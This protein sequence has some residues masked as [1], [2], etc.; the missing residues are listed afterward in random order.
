MAPLSP[1]MFLPYQAPL[2]FRFPENNKLLPKDDEPLP[3]V[4]FAIVPETPPPATMVE[5]IEKVAVE[6]PPSK[7]LSIRALADQ[8]K[9]PEALALCEEALAS[10]KLDTGLHYL[11]A[12]ILQELDRME[13]AGASLKRTLYLDPD[14]ML[15]H[16]ALGNLALRQGGGRAAK[17]HFENA[18]VLLNACREEDILPES[19]GLTAGRFREII[20]A[21][22]ETGALA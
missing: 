18:L 5:T 12:I 22:I 11:R 17:K 7:V 2:S 21:T 15:A 3:W 8:G 9:L 19:E 10:D 13:E 16:F 4:E 20:N 1:E 14:F 6:T